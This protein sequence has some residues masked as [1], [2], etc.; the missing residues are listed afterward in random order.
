LSS[1]CRRFVTIGV[2]YWAFFVV[3]N[4]SNANP[5]DREPCAATNPQ[6]TAW[7][8]D[9][10][11]HTRLSL[12]AAMQDTR[13]RPADAYRY[14]Q[15]EEIGIP[16]YGPNGETLQTAQID[17]PLDFAGVTDHA[18]MLGE[19]AICETPEME[20]YWSL[21]CIGYRWL[22]STVGKYFAYTASHAERLGFC[23]DN[24]LLCVNAAAGPWM[25]TLQAAEQAYDRSSGCSFSSF[26][27]YE[28]TGA[29][30]DGNGG[31]ANLHRNVIFRGAEVPEL[32]GSFVEY[33]N[34]PALWQHLKQ[35][36]SDFGSC[37]AIVIPHNSN[38]SMGFM[39]QDV[40]PSGEPISRQDAA[41]RQRYE[42]L[43]E[44]IQHKGASECYF[45]A[46][47]NDELCDFEQLP[48]NSF[49]GNT[50]EWLAE[51]I[52]P[53]AGHVREVLKD[54]LLLGDTLGV[55]PFKFGF[56]GS[57]DTHRSLA[58]GVAESDFQGHGGAGNAAAEV[59]A[60]GL[61]DEWE[62]NPGGLAVVYAEE[63]SRES[64]FAAMQRRETYATSGPR[65]NVRFFGGWDMSNDLCQSGN[66]VASS[67]SSGVP[68]GGN[69]PAPTVSS[70]AGPVFVVS[71]LKDPGTLASPG[72]DLQRLQIIKGWVDSNGQTR[73]QVFD[74]DGN[75]NNG[76]SVDLTNCET[77]G[78]GAKQ[79]CSVWRDES[80]D[81][82]QS[83]FYYARVVENPSCRWSTYVCNQQKISCSDVDSL[84]A[85]AAQCCVPGIK[86]TVQ[87]RAW[88]SPIWYTPP[89]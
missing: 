24:G 52:G 10:H 50:F 22:P 17:R 63:N 81:T 31:V 54:G 67:Y 74:V 78:A 8:G 68:M 59:D 6:R 75:A 27:A 65:M 55:N 70:E 3:M 53:D 49:S 87:E 48:W 69:L 57:T 79:L 44:M 4:V 47:A 11:V 41:N 80:F 83:A 5:D 30:D 45:G 32:P 72:V 51:P 19:T 13:T 7:F 15:G 71:A 66:L 77:R 61:P 58:G 36:C 42:T 23:G 62:F 34:A 37:D 60:E 12:D 85:E 28:W 56:I 33:P 84:S 76:A 1:P 25:E 82:N 39:F 9:L 2:L 73:E 43:V 29:Y 38:I 21:A 46:G 16:P 89:G 86:R 20:G 40:L 26:A 18:E 14:A 64:L 88:T 35:D